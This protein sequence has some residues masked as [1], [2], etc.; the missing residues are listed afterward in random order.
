MMLQTSE[1]RLKAIN[2]LTLLKLKPRIEVSF[3]AAVD[4]Q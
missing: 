3:L 4:G 2:T 1:N